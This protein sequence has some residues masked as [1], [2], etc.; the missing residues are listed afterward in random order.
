MFPAIL[1]I[2]YCFEFEVIIAVVMKSFFLWDVTIC[3]LFKEVGVSEEHVAS[4]L[5]IEG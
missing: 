5:G 2:I 3:N 4:I 1:G